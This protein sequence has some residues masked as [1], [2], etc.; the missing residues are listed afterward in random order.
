MNGPDKVTEDDHDSPDRTA[1][2]QTAYMGSL[3]IGPGDRCK[4]PSRENE[5]ANTHNELEE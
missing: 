3:V 5:Q 2:T 1:A 4:G